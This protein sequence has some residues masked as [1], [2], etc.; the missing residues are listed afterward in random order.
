[1]NLLEK[2]EAVEVTACDCISPADKNYCERHQAAYEAA[3][4]GVQELVFFWE[5]LRKAQQDL[6]GEGEAS[7]GNDLTYLSFRNCLA[8]TDSSLLEHIEGL[9]R[10]L[11]RNITS[12]FNRTYNMTLSQSAVEEKLIPQEPK[13]KWPRN[14]E[15]MEAY[16]NAMQSLVVRYQDIVELL[17]LQMDGRSFTQQAFYEL[18]EKCHQAAWNIYLKKPK[19]ERKKAVIRYTGYGCQVRNWGRCDEWQL[20]DDTKTIL[21]GI[22]H[23][24]TGNYQAFPPGISELMDYGFSCDNEYDF[25]GCKK[26]VQL[27]MFKNGRVDFKFASDGYAE[28]FERL[29]LGTVC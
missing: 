14:N 13:A 9:H 5:D 19:Y 11:I 24:E 25:P 18:S 26:L 2:F 20:Q 16:H 1:M 15:E 28:E 23:F 6:L 17:I 3:L 21:R 10:V 8:I 12:Y 27:K 4:Q 7:V 22:S 29:Y